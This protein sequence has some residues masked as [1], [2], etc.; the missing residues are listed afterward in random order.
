MFAPPSD[1]ALAAEFDCLMAR[2]GL[3]IPPA[4]QAGYLAAFADLRSQIALLHTTR[5]A[6]VEPSNVFRLVSP[7]STR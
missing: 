5:S 4:R 7:E 1:T 3:A 6:A 2:A